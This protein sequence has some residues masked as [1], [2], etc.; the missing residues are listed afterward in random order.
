MMPD[1]ERTGRMNELMT[2]VEHLLA[3]M[4]VTEPGAGAANHEAPAGEL[5]D[6]LYDAWNAELRRRHGQPDA[7]FEPEGHDENST[8]PAA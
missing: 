7:I 5:M 1:E 6:K 8:K 3:E 4:G 2:A